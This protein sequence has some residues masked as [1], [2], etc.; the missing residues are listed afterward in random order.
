M[1]PQSE[2]PNQSEV[3]QLLKRIEEEYVAA[4]RGLTGLAATAKHQ[5]ISARMENL[6]RLHEGLR[7]V[8]GDEAMKLIAERLNTL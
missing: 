7:T 6:E 3:A 4:T 2:Q 5:A 8:V 1:T